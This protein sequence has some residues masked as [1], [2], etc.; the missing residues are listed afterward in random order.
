MLLAIFFGFGFILLLL[1]FA[2]I[3]DPSLS[4]AVI[5]NLNERQTTMARVT[6][7]GGELRPLVSDSSGHAVSEEV[8]QTEA[9]F[10][11]LTTSLEDKMNELL[12]AAEE[13]GRFYE[14]R[15]EMS[16]WLCLADNSM[17]EARLYFVEPSADR[18]VLQDVRVT[19]PLEFAFS[20][21]FSF[22][23]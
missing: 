17:D 22:H 2:V 20:F 11:T 6:R 19:V 14:E 18:R 7:L 5:S 10:G 21:V 3:G 23:F 8:S 13:L 4:Q 15:N 16:Q 12:R 9:R 1:C